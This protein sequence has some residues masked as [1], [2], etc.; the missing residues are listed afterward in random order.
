M[1][2]QIISQQRNLFTKTLLVATV[3]LASCILNAACD[4]SGRYQLVENGSAVVDT[5]TGLVWQRCLLGSSWTGSTC[6]TATKY[7]LKD[8]LKLKPLNSWRIPN[9][10]EL[11][12]LTEY[13]CYLQQPQ[14]NY[15]SSTGNWMIEMGYGRIITSTGGGYAHLVRN[16]Q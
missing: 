16:P 6:T 1:N 2:M 5:R 15:L 14:G 4:S 7:R 9:I 12:T 3:S 8:A 10:K 13:S 11:A